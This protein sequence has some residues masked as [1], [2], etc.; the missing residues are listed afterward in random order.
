MERRR[1]PANY[2]RGLWSATDRW[3]AIRIGSR[4]SQAIDLANTDR[5]R[6]HSDD[7]NG[8]STVY[9]GA[10]IAGKPST[11]VPVGRSLSP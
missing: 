2:S 1:T 7:A 4:P 6:R 5:R 3:T 8:L 9:V 10:G 11:G